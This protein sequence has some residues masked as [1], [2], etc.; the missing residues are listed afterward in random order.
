VAAAAVSRG[1]ID[2]DILVDDRRGLPNGVNFVAAQHAA[3]GIAISIVS[4]MELI[5][6]CRDARDIRHLQTFLVAIAVVPLTGPVSIRAL[7]WMEQFSLSNGLTIPDALIAATA[8]EQG[9]ILYTK[10]LRHF[11]MLPGL[12]LFRPY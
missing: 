6:G 4:A 9:L 8:Y 11:Q 3:G 7:Q 12:Q 5:A 2:T 1:L 10:N